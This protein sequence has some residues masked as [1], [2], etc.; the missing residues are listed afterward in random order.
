MNRTIGFTV[1]V[2]VLLAGLAFRASTAGEPLRARQAGVVPSAQD[3]RFEL[4][5]NEPI[6]A[7]D[8]RALVSGWSVL[9]FKDRR[10]DRCYVAFKHEDA[11]SV[12]SAV[13]AESR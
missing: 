13:C 9:M 7:P 4:L 11:I 10:S 6:A 2:L 3:V 12:D 5:G 1:L 8:G